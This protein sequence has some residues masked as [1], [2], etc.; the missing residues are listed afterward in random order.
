VTV[1]ARLVQPFSF[2]AFLIGVCCALSSTAVVV[3][4]LS[5]DELDSPEGRSVVGVLV[6][7]DVLV[8]LVLA[9][10]PLLNHGIAE[11]PA[12]LLLMAR[13]LAI[14]LVFA[15]ASGKAISLIAFR[16]ADA[17]RMYGPKFIPVAHRSTS[18]LRF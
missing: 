7:Q 5:S 1:S 17:T 4:V 11:V 14:F 8:G 10:V 18:L 13:N 6:T 9:S 2:Q 12:A 16:Y 3:T 15:Y